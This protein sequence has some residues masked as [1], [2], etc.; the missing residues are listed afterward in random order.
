MNIIFTSLKQ[1][2]AV[3]GVENDTFE[4]IVLISDLQKV[5][6]LY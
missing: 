1:L 5:T 3:F 2:S 4:Q 6:H